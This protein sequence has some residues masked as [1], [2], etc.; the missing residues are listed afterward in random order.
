MDTTTREVSSVARSRKVPPQPLNVIVQ[1][2][3]IDVTPSLRE[4]A[5]EKVGRIARYFDHAQE[6]QVV[7]SVER[8]DTLGKAQVVEVT[9]WGDGMVLRG[10]HASEDMYASIDGVSEKLRKQIEKFRSKLIEKRRI[11]EA[12]KK[13]RMVASAEAALRVTPDEPLDGPRIVRTKRFAMKPMT[14]EEAAL[15]M[16]LLG[17]DFFVFRNTQSQEVNV[18]YKRADGNYGLIEPES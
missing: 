12:R 16:E 4:Y 5:E 8:R 6:A 1:G 11:D 17:H 3:H 14:P 7:L 13:E 18:L 9:V 2:K 15:Q 10:E